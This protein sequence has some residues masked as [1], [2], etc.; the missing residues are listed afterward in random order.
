[1]NPL[2]SIRH[3]VLDLDG[4]LYLGDTVFDCTRPFLATLREFD[5]GC[6]FLTNNSSCSQRDYL[7]K[8]GGMGIAATSADIET[9]AGQTIAYLRSRQPMVE[10]VYVLGTPALRGELS[11]HGLLDC[12]GLDDEPDAVVVGFDRSLTYDRLCRAAYWIDRG[13]PWIATHKDL[14][15][16]SSEP[17]VLVDCGALTA[18]LRAATGRDPE[19]VL[20]KPDPRVLQGIAARHHLT[21]DQLAMVGDRLYTDV[22]MA[23]TA[24]A[25]AVLVLSGETDANR[26]AELSPPADL[27]V[28]HVGELAQLLTACHG[29]SQN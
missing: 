19:A 2:R 23:Q 11:A 14:V 18:C 27:V 21:T 16:P 20:G 7:Q 10:R 25:L 4:T 8:L 13:K 24:G 15:C 1:M 3:F 5:L 17:T 22:Q 12:A 9:S 26:A 29:E 28:D 6:T